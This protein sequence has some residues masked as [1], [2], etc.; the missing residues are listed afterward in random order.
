MV[1]ISLD[2]AI[3]IF[4][5]NGWQL[6]WDGNTRQRAITGLGVSISVIDVQRNRKIKS[7]RKIAYLTD[8]DGMQ[9]RRDVHVTTTNINAGPVQGWIEHFSKY[10]TTTNA[11]ESPAYSETRCRRTGV[12]MDRSN[13]VLDFECVKKEQVMYS[14]EHYSRSITSLNLINGKVP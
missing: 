9:Y 13:P 10:T 11:G 1:P 3:S 5:D 14:G 7:N 12:R 2:G 6:H 8:L 4:S